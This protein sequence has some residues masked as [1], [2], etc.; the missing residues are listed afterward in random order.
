VKLDTHVHS[1]FSGRNSLGPLRPFRRFIKDS[2]LSPEEIYRCAKARGMDL[3][4]ITDRDCIDGVMQIADRPDVIVGCEITTTFPRDGV[5][6][7]LG[8]LDIT[9]A[10]FSEIQRL[11]GNV[12]KLLPYLQRNGIFT[13]LNHPVSRVESGRRGTLTA[14]HVVALLPWVDAIESINSSL[15]A[16]SN[17]AA[18]ALAESSGKIRVAGSDAHTRRAIGRAWVEAPFA[19]SRAQFLAD[20]R[21][22]C[23]RCDGVHGDVFSLTSDIL[24][25]AAGFSRERLGCLWRSRLHPRESVVTLAGLAALSLIPIPLVSALVHRAAQNRFNEALMYEMVQND[26]RPRLATFR[27]LTLAAQRLSPGMAAG[28]PESEDLGDDARRPVLADYLL[29]RLTDDTLH[30]DLIERYLDEVVPNQS[31]GKATRWFWGKTLSTVAWVTLDRCRTFFAQ[32]SS[33]KRRPRP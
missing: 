25:L 7:H 15:L 27:D 33:T 5:T 2:Y 9:E 13:T 31:P 4:T 8:V 1:Y 12:A 3:V 29:S 17:H 18:I 23:V 28:A 26:L 24:R 30:G 6:V 11:R 20:L 32:R 19:H 21:N 10:Q 16:T 22:G 14:F